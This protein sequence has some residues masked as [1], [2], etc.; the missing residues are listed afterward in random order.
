MVVLQDALDNL[1]EITEPDLDSSILEALIRKAKSTAIEGMTESSVSNLNA[2]IKASESLLVKEDARQSELDQAV[3]ALQKALDDLEKIILPE[4]DSSVLEALISKAMQTPFGDYT[5]ESVSSL[6]DQVY[7][8]NILLDSEA[9][10]AEI[11]AQVKALQA[12]IDSLVEVEAKDP[13]EDELDVKKLA[14]LVESIEQI[15]LK[16]YTQETV[17]KLTKALIESKA[18]LSKETATQAEVDASH[19]A[20]L[21]ALKELEK[22]VTPETPEAPETPKDG[23]PATGMASSIGLPVFG[24]STA[25]AGVYLVLKKKNEE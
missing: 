1:E 23:L 8:A 22:M 24:I 3:V 5:K 25:L 14:A 12:A 2:A 10:Q 20:L 6:I 11:D 21:A 9:T 7:Q 4:V 19:D 18:L 16:A 17:S 13:I 15:D